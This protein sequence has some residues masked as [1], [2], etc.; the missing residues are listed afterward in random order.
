MSDDKELKSEWVLIYKVAPLI[1]DTGY[2]NS[3]GISHIDAYR[4]KFNILI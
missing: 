4:D 3:S 2:S 1:L